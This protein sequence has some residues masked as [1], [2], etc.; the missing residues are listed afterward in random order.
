MHALFWIAPH[1]AIGAFLGG[2]SH[3]ECQTDGDCGSAQLCVYPITDGC[4]A[5]GI[6]QDQPSGSH[7][8]VFVQYCGCDGRAVLVACGFTGGSVPV[9]G[10]YTGSCG[11][12]T[13]DA[14]GSCMSSGDC[15]TNQACYYPVAD[16]CSA[17]GVCLE[18]VPGYSAAS[19]ESAPL[20]C[21]CNGVSVES[22]CGGHNGYVAAPV[23][24]QVDM[25]AACSMP[26]PP[27]GGLPSVD[28]GPR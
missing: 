25:A 1:L 3:S 22:V 17:T 9:E 10:P 20:Y 15:G 2:C 21:G 12:G 4:S 24:R 23:S 6:C 26:I 8:N 16:G 19:C 11:H 18:G 28:G 7:C 27:D 13:K 14:G 5:K